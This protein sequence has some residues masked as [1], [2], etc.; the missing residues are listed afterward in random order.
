M[1][2][3]TNGDQNDQ[4]HKNKNSTEEKIEGVQDED[5]ILIISKVTMKMTEEKENKEENKKEEEKKI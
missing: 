1:S 5:E 4:K 3:V 2:E